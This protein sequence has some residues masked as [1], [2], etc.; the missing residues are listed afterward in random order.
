MDT[1]RLTLTG[2]L[3]EIS[4]ALAARKIGAAFAYEQAYREYVYK[5]GEQH[6]EK[7]LAWAAERPCNVLR[8]YSC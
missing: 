6:R 7:V 4:Q 3:Y 2:T 5:C 8:A 1:M